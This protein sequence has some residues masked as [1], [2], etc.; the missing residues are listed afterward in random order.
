MA[1][2]ARPRAGSP[3]TG[4]AG[5]PTWTRPTRRASPAAT[6]AN[7]T[8]GNDEIDDDGLSAHAGARVRARRPA[9]P[10]HGNRVA[11]PGQVAAPAP[12]RGL[13]RP[14]AGAGRRAAEAG[15]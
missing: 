13:P 3:R 12:L 14:D 5:W 6:T 9:V 11:P 8:R 15:G 7:R 1:A 4:S 10:R 2:P